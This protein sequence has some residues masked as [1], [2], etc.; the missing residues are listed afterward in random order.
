V[1]STPDFSATAEWQHRYRQHRYDSILSGQ[2][3][4]GEGGVLWMC[5]A[6]AP[7]NAGGLCYLKKEDGICRSN[8][9]V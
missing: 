3:V 1:L 2:T 8:G 4:G 6:D 5:S 9:E 7:A